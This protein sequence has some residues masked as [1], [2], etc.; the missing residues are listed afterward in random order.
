MLM[1]L[2]FELLAFIPIILDLLFGPSPPVK[3]NFPHITLGAFISSNDPPTPCYLTFEALNT[4][5]HGRGLTRTGK[6]KLVQ[7]ICR[8]LE[9]ERQG[10]TLID[11]NGELFWLVAADLAS[12]GIPAYLMNPSNSGRLVGFNPFVSASKDEA[13]L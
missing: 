10:F 5:L 1:D 7:H 3:I 12:R 9:R 6:S 13:A 8:E 2:T 11:P 4:H